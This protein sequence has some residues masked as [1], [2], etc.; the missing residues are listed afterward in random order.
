MQSEHCLSVRPFLRDAVVCLLLI[1][2]S[3]TGC[4]QGITPPKSSPVDGRVVLGGKP[5]TGVRVTLHPQFKIGTVP[6]LPNGET[7]ADGKFKLSTG[8]PGNGAPPGEYLVSLERPRI[9]SDKANS[10]IE[11]EVDDLKGKFK[12][13]EK[14]P[15]K[16]TIQQGENHLEPFD[17]TAGG[18]N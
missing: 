13:P 11:L 16:V 10:G 2:G 18:K 6:F 17:L 4:K 5:V 12:D 14:S 3:L 9:V 8:A 15:W 7:D 1:F